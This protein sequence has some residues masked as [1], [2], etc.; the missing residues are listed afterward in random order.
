MITSISLTP[1]AAD[2]LAEL[3]RE[4]CTDNTSFVIRYA[5]VIAQKFHESNKKKETRK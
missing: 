4:M 1:A 5:L 3:K 2:A